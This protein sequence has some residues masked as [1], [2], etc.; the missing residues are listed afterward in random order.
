MK[1]ALWTV[2]PTTSNSALGGNRPME[3]V[4]LNGSN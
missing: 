3:R 2:I 4:N 1:G